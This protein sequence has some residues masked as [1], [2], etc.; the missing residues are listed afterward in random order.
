MNKAKFGGDTMKTRNLIGAGCLLAVAFTLAG[1]SAGLLGIPGGGSPPA[2]P[3]VPS[4]NISFCDLAACSPGTTF[5]VSTARTL[6]ISVNWTNIKPGTYHQM[7][8]I[9]MPDGSLYQSM[10]ANF[11]VLE[12]S[13]TA[14]LTDK[15]NIVGTPIRSRELTGDWKV[16]IRLDDGTVIEPVT[17]RLNP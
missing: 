16:D 15:L 2:P 14:Q 3:A 7:I 17:L 12:G 10:S 13:T 8:S 11:E 9:T 5:S 6:R 1:C 4:A